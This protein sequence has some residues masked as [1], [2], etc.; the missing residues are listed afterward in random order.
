[1]KFSNSNF[2]M[3]PSRRYTNNLRLIMLAIDLQRC[4]R[5]QAK[6][7]RPPMR[8]T[9]KSL[10]QSYFDHGYALSQ[11][12]ARKMARRDIQYMDK[13]F[14]LG[15]SEQS[16]FFMQTAFER[17]LHMFRFW[18]NAL[19]QSPKD[20]RLHMML[21][22]LIHAIENGLRADPIAIPELALALKRKYGKKNVRDA[23]QPLQELFSNNEISSYLLL[24]EL[25]DDLE[26]DPDGDGLAPDRLIVS[27]EYDPLLL[28]L[29]VR[30]SV[31]D[32]ADISINL[33]LPGR[34]RN[35][36]DTF[37]KDM[38]AEEKQKVKRIAKAVADSHCWQDDTGVQLV[39]YI[40]Y[41]EGETGPMMLTLW[42]H[43][44]GEY[45]DV[46]V[47]EIHALPTSECQSFTPFG[48]PESMWRQF[49]ALSR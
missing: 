39:P 7:K 8:V 35:I 24:T 21:E 47:S 12:A 20:G 4:S 44:T 25:E 46:H 19:D 36:L 22:G 33:A 27:R 38:D 26:S 15:G 13:I 11:D 16:G 49:T 5:H 17:F 30:R 34:V 3:A 9:S 40:L 6:G 43:Q 1:M 31:G 28:R 48:M 23:K 37:C 10:E 41:R 2:R 18:L 14:A 42:N 32:N 29:K 45:L